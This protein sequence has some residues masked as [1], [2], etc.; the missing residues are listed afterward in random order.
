MK[1]AW[2]CLALF[3]LTYLLSCAL[4]LNDDDDDDETNL[5]KELLS[6]QMTFNDLE[7]FDLQSTT[8]VQLISKHLAHYGMNLIQYSQHAIEMRIITY[9]CI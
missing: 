4:K 8:A 6:L 2:L 5:C 1:P 7:H 9:T 3:V